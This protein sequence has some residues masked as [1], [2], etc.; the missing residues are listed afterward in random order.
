ML[1][2]YVHGLGL[3]GIYLPMLRSMFKL[4]SLLALALPL[5]SF[6][7]DAPIVKYGRID[8]VELPS[9]YVATRPIDIWLPA[10]YAPTKRYAVLYMQ[11][12]QS[13][14]DSTHS[15]SKTEWQV[16]ETLTGLMRAGKIR[17]VIVV[18]IHNT[19]KNRH[20]EYWPQKAWGM[21]EPLYQQK[22]LAQGDGLGKLGMMASAPFADAYVS[23][24]VREIKPFIDKNYSVIP[25]AANT[26]IAGSEMGGLVALYALCEHPEVFGGAACLSTHWTGQRVDNTYV[27]G[28]LMEYLKKNL[29]TAGNHKLYFD[30][31][32]LGTDKLY[33]PHQKTADAILLA[34]KWTPAQWMSKVYPGADNS[35]KAWGARLATPMT[36][37]LK[38]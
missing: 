22:I 13:L 38:R 10:G 12:G 33:A 11:D 4:F 37:L 21:M 17:D 24:I 27:P 6:A 25:D 16:D 32:T 23:Y 26:F 20:A 3:L 19:D 29:P 9:G 31:G 5:V 28:S 15:A 2:T 36:F 8:R 34:K 30:H 14:F 18:A 7:Q 1:I 35:D